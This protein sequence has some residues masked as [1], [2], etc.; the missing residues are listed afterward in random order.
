MNQATREILQRAGA[1]RLE[2]QA[3]LDE[4]T[5]LT[6][7]PGVVTSLARIAHQ[8]SQSTVDPSVLLALNRMDLLA[9]SMATV[10]KQAFAWR[11]QYDVVLQNLSQQR[12]QVRAY[13]A[14]LRNEAELREGRRR[15]QE[16][17]QF[18]HWRMAQGEEAARLAQ[19]ILT[20]QAQ[21]QDHGLSEL[22]LNLADL[23]RIVELFND[24]KTVDDLT[25]LK[26]NKLRPALD[27]LS[28]TYQFDLI[29]DLKIAL[30]GKGFTSDEQNQSII[31]GSG[32]LYT[33][34]RDTLLLRGE[35][36]KLEDDL[37]SVSHEIDAAV[38]AF[39]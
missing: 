5:P 8:L 27:R 25:D 38:A 30:F 12:I 24:E 10:E 11:T 16:A 34:S 1:A 4:N 21:Q 35:R 37:A 2:I 6:E 23:A 26:D 28:L 19:M 17:I 22:K 13:L 32:G 33:L 15:L 29:Q 20:E 39:A 36:E 14:A 3:A 7:T 9:K 18:K 31:V